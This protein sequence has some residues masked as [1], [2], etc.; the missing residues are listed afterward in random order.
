L[1]LY[2][3]VFFVSTFPHTHPLFCLNGYRSPELQLSLGPRSHWLCAQ[4]MMLPGIYA[5]TW[6]WLKYFHTPRIPSL[7]LVA[8]RLMQFAT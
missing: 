6:S 3:S 1:I 4:E 5:C 7:L 8:P 2:T